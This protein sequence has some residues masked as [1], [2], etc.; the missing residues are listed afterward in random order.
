MPSI[1]P[2]REQFRRDAVAVVRS[3]EKSSPVLALAA[4]CA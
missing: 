3:S 2:Y 1:P 4:D